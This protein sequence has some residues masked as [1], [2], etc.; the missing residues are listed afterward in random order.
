MN[1]WCLP[2]QIRLKRVLRCLEIARR[3]EHI[4][5]AGP[6]HD[7]HRCAAA[8]IVD[9]IIPVLVIIVIITTTNTVIITANS[10]IGPPPLAVASAACFCCCRCCCSCCPFPPLEQ[11]PLAQAFERRQPRHRLALKA[12]Q[13]LPGERLQ[14]L[15]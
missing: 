6:A 11:K 8:V 1:I 10:S 13:R 7:A 4:R 5:A 12:R 9:A 14:V 2:F 15:V 3:I